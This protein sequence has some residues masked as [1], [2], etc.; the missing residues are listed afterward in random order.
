[1][2][3]SFN[4]QWTD[5]NV[6]VLRT[7]YKYNV[8]HLFLNWKCLRVIYSFSSF[9]TPK[10]MKD[11]LGLIWE[12]SGCQLSVVNCELSVVSYVFCACS[13]RLSDLNAVHIS[14]LKSLY[15]DFS[16]M[17]IWLQYQCVQCTSW[18]ANVHVRRFD[19]RTGGLCEKKLTV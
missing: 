2:A 4:Y 14:G 11:E 1:M 3:F 6:I 7:V 8:C 13:I 12:T 18:N 15:Y 9:M 17:I 19:W 16:C 5:P 10:S